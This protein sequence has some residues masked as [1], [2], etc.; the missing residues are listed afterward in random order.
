M[1]MERNSASDEQYRAS[2][3]AKLHRLSLRREVWNHDV[4]GISMRVWM[5]GGTSKFCMLDDVSSG[6]SVRVVVHRIQWPLEE[7][8]IPR[9]LHGQAGASGV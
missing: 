4:I 3:R 5:S 8:L 6:A 2:P 1:Q 9:T 7:V